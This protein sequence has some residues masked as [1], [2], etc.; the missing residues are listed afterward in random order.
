MYRLCTVLVHDNFLKLIQ[1]GF[2]TSPKHSKSVAGLSPHWDCDY[3]VC[4]RGLPSN[5][6]LQVDHSLRFKSI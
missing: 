5:Y 6:Q 4:M 3:G 2:N 1:G